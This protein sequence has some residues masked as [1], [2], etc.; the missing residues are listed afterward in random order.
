[1]TYEQINQLD[2]KATQFVAKLHKLCDDV[3][4]KPDDPFHD[5]AGYAIWLLYEWL[6]ENHKINDDPSFAE[7]CNRINAIAPYI[8]TLDI[9][10]CDIANKHRISEFRKVY[11]DVLEYHRES[12]LSFF[13]DVS[14]LTCAGALLNEEVKR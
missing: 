7:V 14:N 1:M 13:K 4:A 11:L 2:K 9:E 12:F 5:D 10:M 3:V 6:Y 8:L